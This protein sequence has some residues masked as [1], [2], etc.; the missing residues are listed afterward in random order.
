L[1][2]PRRDI[3]QQYLILE[4]TIGQYVGRPARRSR[5]I[6]CQEAKVTINQSAT[7][8]KLLIT[9]SFCALLLFSGCGG[10]V[11]SADSQ[12]ALKDLVMAGG[13]ILLPSGTFDINCD[14]QLVISRATTLSGQGRGITV[15]NDMCATGDTVFVDL[16]NPA[17]VRIENLTIIHAAASG[18]AVRLAG[19]TQGEV[20]IVRRVL[21]LSSVEL[22]G[23]RD[24]LVSEGQNLLFVQESII[25]GC[26]NDGAQIGSF[27]V[28]FHDNWFG[29]NGRN[30]VTFVGSGFCAACTGNEYWLNHGHGLVYDVTGISDPRHVGDYI[31]SNGDVGLVVS[32]VRDF[33][34]ANGW[35][36]TNQNGGA[37]IGDTTIGAVVVGNTFTNNFGPNLMVTATSGPLHITGNVSSLPHDP[38]DASIN[39]APCVSLNKL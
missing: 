38:C 2:Q 11:V 24:C 35:I 28:T 19:G 3:S 37:V 17:I 4:F 10:R 12:P 14:G 23:A 25:L 7:Q 15:L 9:A 6:A 30:G 27:G 34:F 13:T 18:T 21:K 1:A 36:G 16:T 31:D 26:G 22:G 29:K 5:E 32:G 39:G 20:P 33:T 8:V